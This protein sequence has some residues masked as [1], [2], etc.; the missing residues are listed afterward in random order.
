PVGD[1]ET[2]TFTV[3]AS[4]GTI[5][6]T[7]SITTVTAISINDPPAA[8]PDSGPGF[9]T[10]D[11]AGFVTGNV[12]ADDVDPDSGDSF[13][14][15]GIDTSRTLGLVT[16]LGDGTFRYDPNGKFISLPAGAVATDSFTYTV[17]DKYG[18]SSSG[19][20]MVTI[21]GDNQPPTAKDDAIA[22]NEGSGPN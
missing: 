15:L 5:S 9:V 7:N 8:L 22:V 14:L 2:N 3:I 1:S 12:L 4:D 16:N 17:R 19:T 11:A 6:R 10:T 20:V 21:N 13:K 18:S